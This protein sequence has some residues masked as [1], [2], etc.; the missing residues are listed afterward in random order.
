MSTQVELKDEGVLKDAI[1]DV[2]S[3]ASR[4]NW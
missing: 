1:S 2:R 3:D 4:T